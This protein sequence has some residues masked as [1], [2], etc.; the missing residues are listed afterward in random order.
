M[1]VC[2]YRELDS[3]RMEAERS[4]RWEERVERCAWGGEVVEVS[5][6]VRPSGEAKWGAGP[7]KNDEERREGECGSYGRS[8]RHAEAGSGVS[9][10]RRELKLKR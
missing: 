4:G 7:A 9:C 5:L 3:V 6:G 10:N 1:R 2:G 8:G